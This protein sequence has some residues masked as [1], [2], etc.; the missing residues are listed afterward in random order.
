MIGQKSNVNSRIKEII[1]T[2]YRGNL[3]AFSKELGVS[4]TTISSVVHNGASP[5]TEI[6]RRIGMELSHQISVD[7]VVTGRGEMFHEDTNTSI[8]INRSSDFHHMGINNGVEPDSYVAALK[9]R[10]AHL[11]SLLNSSQK[12]IESQQSSISA[13]TN[14]L[15]K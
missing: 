5:S 7:W 13:L 8:N 9:E 2:L 14:L 6:V 1:D 10:I 4:R 11:E 15:N 12:L 3:T